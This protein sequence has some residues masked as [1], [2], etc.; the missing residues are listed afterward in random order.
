M[1]DFLFRFDT[2]ADA[3]PILGSGLNLETAAPLV[4][5]KM[6]DGL[7][8]IARTRV[9]LRDESLDAIDPETGALIPGARPSDGAWF[10]LCTSDDAAATALRALPGFMVE[11]ERPDTP[12]HWRATVTAFNAAAVNP[13]EFRIATVSP[14]WA[15]GQ[16]VFD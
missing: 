7:A 9:M 15:G 16:Y 4:A 5:W 1:K 8:D 10:A 6:P 13:A 12:T 2:A 14:I 3:V 11:F